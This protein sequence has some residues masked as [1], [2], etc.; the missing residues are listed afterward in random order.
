MEKEMYLTEEGF[1]KLKLE[2]EGLVN[3]KR[4]EI[5]GKI[6]RAKEF[7]DLSENA[8][9][10][11]AKDEQSFVEG[12]IQE[13][14]H[15]LKNAKVITNKGAKSCEVVE[16]G[17]TVKVKLEAGDMKLRIV[18]SAE[19]DPEAGHI[20]HESPIGKALLGKKKGEEVEIDIPAGTIKYKIMDI[21][22]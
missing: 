18:G 7:G 8:E 12:R 10:S 13:L 19:A 2:L 1:A 17:C 20:S 3:V 16:I 15:L 4:K 22:A 14:E 9:Y 5:S 11:E 6:R 21:M